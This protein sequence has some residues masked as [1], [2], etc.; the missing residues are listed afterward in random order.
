[1]VMQERD[2]M[3]ATN[4]L[5]RGNFQRKGDAVMPDVPAFLPPLAVETCPPTAGAPPTDT[6]PPAC[7]EGEGALGPLQLSKHVMPSSE[8]DNELR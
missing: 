4:V 5:L 7:S 8:P 3:R 2:E 6:E 1:M